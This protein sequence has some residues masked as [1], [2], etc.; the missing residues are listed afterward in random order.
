MRGLAPM[1]GQL[2]MA[3]QAPMEVPKLMLGQ[4]KL[5]AHVVIETINVVISA[6]CVGFLV[7]AFALYLVFRT[8]TA[9]NFG[10]IRDWMSCTVRAL[11]KAQSDCVAKWLQ[12]PDRAGQ[13]VWRPD[14]S[15]SEHE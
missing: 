12:Y 15:K 2:L 8:M 13:R 1:G 4:G 10:P 6:A 7:T 9:M 11:K 5:L 14:C 3:E